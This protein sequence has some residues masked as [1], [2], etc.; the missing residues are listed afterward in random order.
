[1]LVDLAFLRV[2]LVFGWVVRWLRLRL[3]A[4]FLWQGLAA[5]GWFGL[6]TWFLRG[7]V[8]LRLGVLSGLVFWFAVC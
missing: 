5:F 8:W 6:V 7:S 4:C 3:L 1:M 2:V